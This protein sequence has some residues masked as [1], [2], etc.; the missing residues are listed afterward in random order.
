LL[1]EYAPRVQSASCPKARSQSVLFRQSPLRE[2][3]P[4]AGLGQHRVGGIGN[5]QIENFLKLPIPREKSLFPVSFRAVFYWIPFPLNV[6]VS[7][8]PALV[9]MVSVPAGIA[10]TPV[11]VA[12]SVMVQWDWAASV[13]P[14]VPPAMV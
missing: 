13:L 12:V 10:P 6:T 5:L 3:P 14:Q 9:S 8:V 4:H 7:G 11:G 2:R 1:P